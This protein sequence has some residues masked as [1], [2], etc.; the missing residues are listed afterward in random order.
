MS[1]N[2]NGTVVKESGTLVVGIGEVGAALAEVLERRAP[3]LRQDLEPFEFNEQIGVM[4][5]C[6]TFTSP[7]QYQQ[8]A[9]SYIERFRPALT[10]VNSTV[11]PG[12]TRA[13]ATAS[14]SSVAFSPVRGKHAHMIE[15]MMRYTKFVSAPDPA[16]ARKAEAHFRAAGM[17]TRT[18]TRV[19][20]L[21]LAKLAETTYF[22]VLIAFAQEINRYSKRVN[23]DYFEA[24]DFF[25]EVDYLPPT[26]FFPG[27]IGGH[28]VIPNIRLLMRIAESGLLDAVVQSN[29]L[30]SVEL[31][32][33]AVEARPGSAKSK[34]QDEGDLLADR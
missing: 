26:R 33:E 34:A 22:G 21:E 9:L 16:T 5:L 27:F 2:S 28:C 19:E 24:V 15:D 25:E 31:E 32:Q 13:I 10:I 3:V 7:L 23:G 4:H 1:G 14:G 30:R 11:L 6:I 17:K 8:A 29:E 12:T 20:T 18:M